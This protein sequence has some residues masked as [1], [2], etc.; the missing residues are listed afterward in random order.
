MN[1][2]DKTAQ[3]AR[4]LARA[5][6]DQSRELFLSGSNSARISTR[7]LLFYYSFLNLV[8]A[9]LIY[10]DYQADKKFDVKSLP[11]NHGM[12][13]RRNGG[14]DEI[15][16]AQ[17]CISDKADSVLK[18]LWNKIARDQFVPDQIRMEDVAAQL[19][20]G[21]RIWASCAQEQ[22]RFLA[23]ESLG[24]WTE[25]AANTLRLRLTLNTKDIGRLGATAEEI[26]TGACLQDMFEKANSIGGDLHD[27]TTLTILQDS[28]QPPYTLKKYAHLQEW[29]RGFRNHIWTNVT[30]IPPYR[31][32]YIYFEKEP[33]IPRFPQLISIYAF[34][35]YLGS[36]T[37]YR[38]H[39]F[40]NLLNG[41]Y[42][43]LV[44]ECITNQPSQFVYLLAS[45]FVKQDVTRAAII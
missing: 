33:R 9:Y 42:G 11:H 31:K 13:D 6:I 21:H 1:D 36:I 22:E 10:D 8:K 23:I 16:E 41:K 44:E 18:A 34:F 15:S 43:P 32:Y 30:S 28:H 29:L 37:R 27:S 19:L 35:F 45:E 20:Q 38:P 7:P 25:N 39:R 14:E 40:E 3:E 24:V 4:L 17:I 2:N 26:I 5:F 12:H